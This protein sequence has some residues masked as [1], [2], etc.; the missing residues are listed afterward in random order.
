MSE[1]Y[2]FRCN[3]EIEKIL[4]HRVPPFCWDLM[5]YSF[6]LFILIYNNFYI[7][8]SYGLIFACYGLLNMLFD[9]YTVTIEFANDLL[10]N[11]DELG[12]YKWSIVN[13]K[14]NLKDS[15][16]KNTENKI[17]NIEEYFINKK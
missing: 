1:R 10:P 13:K 6:G 9:T 3:I 2:K 11:Y 7:M 8:V 12:F 17:N 5:G 16:K 15:E 4:K 14:Y